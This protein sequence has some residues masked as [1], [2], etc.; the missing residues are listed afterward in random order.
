VRLSEGW[1]EGGREGGREG[2]HQSSCYIAFVLII[3]YTHNNQDHEYFE[4][5]TEKK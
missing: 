2:T 4:R 5:T 1:K 3:Q